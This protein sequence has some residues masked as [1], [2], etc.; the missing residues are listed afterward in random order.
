MKTTIHM[1]PLEAFFRLTGCLCKYWRLQ[2]EKL[3]ELNSAM[4]VR[5]GVS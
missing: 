5:I 3:M 2:F 4:A 1:K